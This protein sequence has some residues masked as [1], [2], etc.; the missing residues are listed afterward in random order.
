ML[1]YAIR[2]KKAALMREMREKFVRQAAERLLALDDARVAGHTLLTDQVV[3][4]AG[5]LDVL[6]DVRR[7][8]RR[9][10]AVPSQVKRESRLLDRRDDALRL[11]HQLGL[12]QPAGRLGRGDEPHRMLGAHVAVDP[13]LH[14]LGTQLRDRVARVDPFGAALAAVVATGAGPQAVLAVQRLEALVKKKTEQAAIVLPMTT[15]L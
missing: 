8:R 9:H 1:G 12:A 6:R 4:P 7:E 13:L 11:R 3:E 5:L 10:L 14:R 15:A 2:K